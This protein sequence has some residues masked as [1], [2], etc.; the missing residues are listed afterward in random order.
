VRSQRPE[1]WDR[2]QA[3]ESSLGMGGFALLR[4]KDKRT[5]TTRDKCEF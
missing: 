3:G 5:A 2:E 4:N 1:E